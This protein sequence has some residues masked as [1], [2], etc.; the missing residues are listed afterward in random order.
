MRRPASSSTYACSSSVRPAQYP[1]RLLRLLPSKLES[2]RASGRFETVLPG[3]YAQEPGEATGNCAC[4]RLSLGGQ[5][6][7]VKRRSGVRPPNHGDNGQRPCRTP[8]GSGG[9]DA[10]TPLGACRSDRKAPAR[11]V[12]VPAP[13]LVVAPDAG[14]LAVS[15]RWGGLGARREPG[16]HRPALLRLQPALRRSDQ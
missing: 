7:P 1:T 14:D 5:P 3:P 4:R 6:S 8:S 12:R 16:R 10:A 2:P 15:Q 13:A 9:P 11:L